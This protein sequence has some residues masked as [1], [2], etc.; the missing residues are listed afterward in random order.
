MTT[1]YHAKYF[2]YELTQ[3]VDG[4]D[5]RMCGHALSAETDPSRHR[6]AGY[7]E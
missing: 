1:Q 3:S 5:P 6:P 4:S 7:E 2:A